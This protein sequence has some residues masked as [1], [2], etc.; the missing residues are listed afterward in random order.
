MVPKTKQ[1][2]Q[3]ILLF[4]ILF[5]GW[6]V[7]PILSANQKSV[8]STSFE[9]GLIAEENKDYAKA[10]Q[11]YL[12]DAK[13]GDPMAENKVGEL[14]CS[15]QGVFQTKTADEFYKSFSDAAVWFKKAAAQGNAQAMFH[16][17]SFCE[18]GNRG[19]GQA[20]IKEA[21]KWYRK[22]GVAG[23]PDAYC[24]LGRLTDNYQERLEWYQK[25]DCC[26]QIGLGYL[27]GDF[28]PKDETEAKKWFQKGGEKG[29]L[30]AQRILEN[31][32]GPQ[33]W[34]TDKP[35]DYELRM[36]LYEYNQPG[37]NWGAIESHLET[38]QTEG[39]SAAA[40][41]LAQ[42]EAKLG[43][44][45]KRPGNPDCEAAIRLFQSTA[46][47]SGQPVGLGSGDYF[48]MLTEDK[49]CLSESQREEIVR[50]YQKT[51][52]EGGLDAARVLGLA[53]ESGVG[54]DKDLSLAEKYYSIAEAPGSKYENYRDDLRIRM[55]GQP[56]TLVGKIKCG[57]MAIGG[58]TTGCLFT[59]S[60]PVTWGHNFVPSLE[61]DPKTSSD[62]FQQEAI[63]RVTGTLDWFN[64]V[65]R[66][67]RIVIRNAHLETP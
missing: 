11:C 25:G 48:S 19:M 2:F 12:V 14:L 55:N 37:Q 58:E 47:S 45:K 61:F 7:S 3:I 6:S 57:Y 31:L 62:E 36:A 46:C 24:A 22:A 39:N 18:S 54:V 23:F 5:W 67:N 63:Y 4:Q 53:Y 60:S 66:R 49:N 28:L 38:S 13:Q 41:Y 1:I 21:K 9:Q 52:Q 59:P 29:D 56:V 16:L 10:Y 32:I 43:I 17:G 44:Y 40:F 65:E 42:Y 33:H 30:N 34:S 20:N 15:G 8:F 50:Y 26:T 35:G 51:A 64:G 27:Q